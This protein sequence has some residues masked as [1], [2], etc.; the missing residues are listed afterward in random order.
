[1]RTDGISGLDARGDADARSDAHG[2]VAHIDRA[3]QH[4]DETVSEVEADRDVTG[5]W[6]G[7]RELVAAEASGE[8]LRADR[9]TYPCRHLDQ[10]GI[11]DRMAVHVVDRL[12]IVEI[13]VEQRHRVV[14]RVESTRELGAVDEQRQ[15]VVRSRPSK[16]ALR[17]AV[18]D[19]QRGDAQAD[20]KRTW[21]HRQ[22]DRVMAPGEQA[23]D[24][25]DAVG[26]DD[27]GQVRRT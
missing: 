5:T 25:L 10:H 13:D 2:E 20:V 18:H 14:H 23:A 16:I 19:R 4:I 27:G 11:A 22:L 17:S 8:A 15:R 21:V 12:E 6:N 1:M 24:H 7:D 9:V 26:C 3:T